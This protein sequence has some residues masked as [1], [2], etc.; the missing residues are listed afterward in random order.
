[1]SS[2]PAATSRLAWSVD[3]HSSGWA[4]ASPA[5]APAALATTATGSGKIGVFVVAMVAG[6]LLYK[7]VY[8]ASSRRPS[9]PTATARAPKLTPTEAGAH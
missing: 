9:R 3:R 6:M 1:M 5:A 2:P 7:V 8:C 4:G